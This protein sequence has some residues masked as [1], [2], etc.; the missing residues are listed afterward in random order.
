MQTQAIL[1]AI[2]LFGATLLLAQQPLSTAAVFQEVLP[3]L[4]GRLD[5]T[6]W[7]NLAPFAEFTT[8]TPVF[9]TVPKARTEVRL[10][11]GPKALY[12]GAYCH[13]A[14]GIRADK[15]ARDGQLTGDWFQISLDTWND[16]RL[17]FD[18]T[19]TAAGVQHDSRQGAN[20]WDAIW[21]S[22]TTRHA[23][24]WS[25]EIRIPYTALRFPR[26]TEQDWGLQCTRFDRTTGETSTWNPQ[27]PLVQDRV[28]QFGTLTGL[29]GLQQDRRR[30]LALHAEENVSSRYAPFALSPQSSR[31]GLDGRIGL[32]SSATLDFTLLPPQ[33]FLRNQPSAF[34][35]GRS[36]WFDDN[37]PEPR[38]FLE[39]ELDL[40]SKNPDMQYRPYLNASDFIWRIDTTGGAPALVIPL[41]N[42]GRLLQASKL[43][44]RTAG[45][46]RFG[47][48]NA[49]LGPV[50]AVVWDV[51]PPSFLDS[52]PQTTLQF[53]SNYN[54]ASAEYILP[55]NGF[56]HFSNASLLA[57]KGHT[58]VAPTLRFQVRD[59]SNGYEVRGGTNWRYALRN[60]TEAIGYDY[61][62]SIA[63]INRRWGWAVSHTERG[64]TARQPDGARQQPFVRYTTADVRYQDYRPRGV[65]LNRFG[66]VGISSQRVADQ[67]NDL[68]LQG[69]LSGLDKHFRRW[70]IQAQ[71]RPATRL[72]QYGTSGAFIA[73]RLAPDLQVQLAFTSD[74]RKRFIW[75]T[76]VFGYSTLK[77]EVPRTGATAHATW[78]LAPRWTVQGSTRMT[79]N[80]EML[81]LL[82][83]PGRWIFERANQWNADGSLTLAWYPGTR[84]H[85]WGTVLLERYGRRRNREAVELETG[86]GLTPVE[87]P[88]LAYIPGVG[89]NNQYSV[90][91][92]YFFSSISQIRFQ[93]V[94]RRN[95]IFLFLPSGPEYVRHGDLGDTGLT[96]IWFLDGNRR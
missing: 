29:L 91:F 16:D 21:Q 76:S 50:K 62:F 82:P 35:R 79:C 65:F 95:P 4:D 41:E 83:A 93:Y 39:E 33:R 6:C 63:R 92:Q 96:L 24:G 47:V 31:F 56:V 12:I 3:T 9:G 18:F 75:N 53:V 27:D 64:R 52:G 61:N 49:L 81:N 90:G 20:Q 73:R 17:V 7:Q 77:R 23:D 2:A 89:D 54:F 14:A 78:V 8:S 26:K 88:L 94:H 25:L 74:L 34:A 13:N 42:P 28:L 38:Q 43:T 67:E 19:V 10:F 70:S 59:R 1:T 32:S 72:I 60:K 40:F 86:G 48:Y 68:H 58:S 45:N 5:D 71:T 46:W 66:S 84:W 57:G 37:A 69:A 30:S 87:W 44:A 15:G 80:F 55:N 36:R 11:Y 85:V 51:L 22:A